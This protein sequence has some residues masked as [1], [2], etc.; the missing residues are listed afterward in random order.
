MFVTPL[1]E[2][3]FPNLVEHEEFGGVSTGKYSLTLMF[4]KKDAATIERALEEAGAGAVGSPLRVIPDDA[5]YDAGMVRLKG[6]SKFPVKVVDTTK[7]ELNVDTITQG[8][9]CRMAVNF[10]Q[11]DVGG[12]KGIAVYL[13][14]I[15]LH[16][17]SK[18]DVDW[19]D[20]E[21]V[22]GEDKEDSPPW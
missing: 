18:Y 15:M 6:K 7:A 13:E 4:P 17:A 20:C 2:A 22:P 8:A 12:N 14:Q 21:Y 16:E 1:G 9:K 10:V 5:Q 11:Y 19:G 3:R